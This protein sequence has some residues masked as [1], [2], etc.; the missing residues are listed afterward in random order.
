MTGSWTIPVLLAGVALFGSPGPQAA[1]GPPAPS[2]TSSQLAQAD[3]T[4]PVDETEDEEDVPIP[5]NLRDDTPPPGFGSKDALPDTT[6][7]ASARD[8]TMISLP[9]DPET[10][11]YDQPGGPPSS[12]LPATIGAKP[13]TPVPI[14]PKPKGALFGLGPAVIILGIAVLHYFVL[15]TVGG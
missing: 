13:P 8:S 6:G 3:T 10:L 4:S 12:K 1:A 2:G 5:E 11:R 14:P 15:R 7:A 9:A